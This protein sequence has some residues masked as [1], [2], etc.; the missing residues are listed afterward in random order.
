MYKI[1]RAEFPFSEDDS[2]T[3]SR[4]V[5]QLS[6]AYGKYKLVVVA[7][8][9]SSK[10]EK[11]ETDIGISKS[12]V[13]GLTSDSIIRL[14]KLHSILLSKVSAEIGVLPKN[15]IAEVKKKLARLFQL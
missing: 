4:P 8:I 10:L 14:H 7:Y 3:K 2:K 11:L 1:L 15:K 13:S 9:T 12:L 5:L 6:K